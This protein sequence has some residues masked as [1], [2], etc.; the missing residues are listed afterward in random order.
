MKGEKDNKKKKVR[1]KYIYIAQF[2][3]RKGK[4]GREI[5]DGQRRCNFT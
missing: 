1:K 2:L 3:N 4:A 5:E